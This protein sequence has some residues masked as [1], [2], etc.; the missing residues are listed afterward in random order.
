MFLTMFRERG[1]LKLGTPGGGKVFV[2]AA[3]FGARRLPTTDR[4]NPY[5]DADQY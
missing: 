3:D 5:R 1:G 4:H 2:D